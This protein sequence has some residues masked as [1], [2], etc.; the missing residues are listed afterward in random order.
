MAFLKCCI[1]IMILKATA[2]Q[3][4]FDFFNQPNENTNNKKE[5][6][7]HL[8]KFNKLLN[9]SNN[10]YSAHKHTQYTYTHDMHVIFT[11]H[12]FSIE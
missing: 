3:L 9:V 6:I 10:T 4:T 2:V 11:V 5:L 8:G 12:T 1:I 7:D